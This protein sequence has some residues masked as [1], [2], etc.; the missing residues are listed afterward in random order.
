MK[1]RTE[2]E[3]KLS[4]GDRRRFLVKELHEEDSEEPSAAGAGE[5][6]L[7]PEQ[8][9][10]RD[11][12]GAEKPQTQ[13][14]LAQQQQQ[15]QEA[16]ASL[17][18][19]AGEDSDTELNDVQAF[20]E[21]V[22]RQTELARYVR[23]QDIPYPAHPDTLVPEYRRI[24]RST[25]MVVS[26]E[27][28]EVDFPT[29]VRRD[30]F[31]ELPPPAQHPWTTRPTPMGPFIT[32]GDGQINIRG[33]TGEVGFD[34]RKPKDLA[35]APAPLPRHW[36]G[37]QHRSILNHHLPQRNGTTL[38]DA[39]VKH[40]FEWTGRGVF[41]TREIKKGE[42]LMVVR[43]TG[44]N[45]GVKGEM[46]R[47]E[48]IVISILNDCYDELVEEAEEEEDAAREAN[49]GSA[50]A[51]GGGGGTATASE[52]PKREKGGKLSFL[53]DWVL[54]GQ[55]S[56]LLESWPKAS[57]A[58]VV[59]GIG[60]EQ[61]LEAL[62]LH[63]NHIAR[64]AAVVDLNSFL[65]ES[66]FAER[67]GMAYFPEA[68]FLNHS[69]VPNA[70]YDIIPEP[71][72]AESSYCTDET[73]A[74][75][76]DGGELEPEAGGGGGRSGSGGGN[77]NDNSN[78][79]PRGT[80]EAEPE[81]GKGE[82]EERKEDEGTAVEQRR[83]DEQAEGGGSLVHYPDLTETGAPRYL[84]CC[85]ALQDIPAG[86]EI[87][88]SYVPPDWSFDNRQYVLHDRY[89]FW[90]KCPKCA[91][92]LDAKYMRGS[93]TIVVM[94]IVCV[95]LQLIVLYQRDRRN[96]RQRE[97]DSLASLTEDDRARAL[98]ERGMSIADYR[99]ALEKQRLQNRKGLFEMLEERKANDQYGWDGMQP[100]EQADFFQKPP[101]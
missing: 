71:S 16:Q 84:F 52:A 6:T 29:F 62:E 58:R 68:G 21:E 98:R 43:S 14:E 59:E 83:Q 82:E 100:K 70:T 81:E 40:S 99:D 9:R 101:R 73:L 7:S 26:A 36:R 64:L 28:T 20:H 80:D 41:A 10:D 56:A 49:K 63:P 34:D 13:Q 2:R 65:V 55:P 3:H 78:K 74:G 19:V 94:L 96:N 77:H 12:F 30:A 48:E 15:Q 5:S 86:T 88:I 32:H 67:K 85:R 57:T 46:R 90:C 4:P 76:S 8:Q 1:L 60:G 87:T 50:K 44:Q 18:T 79:G 27:A 93:K 42:I 61:V 25:K 91:P 47:L 33:G 92:T 66:F 69:C 51:G 23:N 24:K 22:R 72:F 31:V 45:V 53:H 38:Q 17:P 11:V 75:D 39:V 35:E 97:I 37:L 89:N 95:L 54:T